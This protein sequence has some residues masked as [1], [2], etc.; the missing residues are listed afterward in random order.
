MYDSPFQQASF[1]GTRTAFTFHDLIALT[2]VWSIGP[3]QTPVPFTHAYSPPDRSTPCRTTCWPVAEFTS[4]L[5]DTWSCGA[6]A[7]IVQVKVADPEAPVLSVAV[8]VTVE[9]PGVVG[10]PVISPVEELI[11]RPAGR[12]VAP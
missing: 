10:L 9:A 7:L 3:S 12:P 1:S 2:A 8:T 4:L 5:P 11:E 6:G